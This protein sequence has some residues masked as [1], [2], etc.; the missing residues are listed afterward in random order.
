MHFRR[1]LVVMML[2]SVT[3]LSPAAA[4]DVFGITQ[5]YPSKEGTASW[6]SSHWDNGNER[7][8]R[9]SQDPD[10]PTDWTED[11]S[12]GTDGFRIDGEGSMTMSGSG[13]RFHINSLRDGKVSAQFFRDIEFT[14]YYQRHGEG[15]Q[16]WGGMVVGLR[17]GPLGHA[18]AGG[19]DCDATTYY[20]RFRNDGKWDF[21]KELKHPGST[22]WSGSGF[23]RQDPLWGGAT[24]PLN[25]WIGMKYAIYNIN[26]DSAVRLE[27]YIDSV[28][29]GNPANGGIWELVGT[30]TDSGNWPSG[31]VS[32]CDYAEDAIILEGNGTVLMRTDGDTAVYT[33]VSVREIEPA[34]TGVSRPDIGRASARGGRRN[35]SR[36]V[37]DGGRTITGPYG[38]GRKY[39]FCSIDGKSLKTFSTGASRCTGKAILPAGVY[40]LFP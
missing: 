19:D 33:M 37:S 5:L 1:L 31:D 13:P 9:Y 22:Y 8:V 36:V 29:N 7:V 17:S 15:G 20:A 30:V 24:L 16:N 38:T 21:E 32:G 39:R 26:D 34:G 4:I 3:G 14:A 10:D 6:N 2:L 11:H 18:S 12:G 25:R 35:F 28:S 40:I 23:N 27:L